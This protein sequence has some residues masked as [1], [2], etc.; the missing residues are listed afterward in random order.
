VSTSRYPNAL[1]AS[2]ATALLLAAVLT[3]AACGGDDES[4]AQNDTDEPIAAEQVAAKA[5]DAQVAPI[6]GRWQQ[7][8]TCQQLVDALN[9]EGLGAVAP[10]MV[11]D[12]FPNQSYNEL[13]AKD[14]VCSGATP[15][16]HSHFFTADS[17][18]GSVDQHG[19]QVDDG[20]YAIVDS[21]T[22]QIGDGTFDYR[23][24]SGTLQLTPVMTD[25]QR[26]EA[27]RHPERF[28]TAGWMVAVSYPGSKWKKVPCQGWC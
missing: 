19:N 8:H 11:G 14:D 12:F 13:A 22:I 28:S 16:Q 20:P 6:V 21:N 27:L 17:A 3:F 26:R 24:E 23:I 25:K 7:V 9:A 10:A 5:S 2:V 15:Q 1:A 18:F 4:S